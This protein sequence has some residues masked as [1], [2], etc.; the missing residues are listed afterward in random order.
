MWQQT[1]SRL[2]EIYD[3]ME[4]WKGNLKTIE[5]YF[6]TGVVAYFLFIKWLLFLNLFIFALIFLF[7]TLPTILLSDQMNESCTNSSSDCCAFD[8]FNQTINDNNIILDIFQ[9]TGDLERT[10]LF[11]GYYKNI[12]FNISNDLYYYNLPLSYICVILICLLISLIL[13]VRSAAKGFKERLI[14][15]EGQ[16]YHY[17]NIVFSSWDFCIQNKKSAEIKH[18]AI[19]N[20]IVV[21]LENDRWENDH[22]RRTRNERYK[23]I[24]SRIIVNFIVLG[25]LAACGCAIYYIFHISTEQLKNYDQI[26]TT[27]DQIGNLFYEFLPSLT[28]VCLNMLIPFIFR[29]LINFEDY[30]PVFVLRLTLIRTVLLRLASL[31]VL[32]ASLYSKITCDQPQD[33]D[34]CYNTKCNVP[35]CWETYVGQQFYKLLLTDFI[36]H[37]IITFGVNSV[38]AFL[39]KHIENKFIRLIG[40]QSF[41]LPKHVLDVVYSQTLC[42]VG[43]FYAPLLSPIASITFFLMFYIKRFA[44]LYNSKPSTIVYRASRSNSMFMIVL[45]VSY[46]FALL[47]LV[48]SISELVPSRSCGPFRDLESVWAL[49]IN[50]LM[51]TPA[52]IR[53]IGFF[54][55]TAGFVIPLFV[56]LLLLLYYYT[57]VNAANRH[58]VVVLKNQLV[59]EGHDKQFLLDRLSMFI[60]QENQKRLMRAEAMRE[61]DRNISSN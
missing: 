51:E 25:I 11:Y 61:G 21:T 29:V 53:N 10:V 16:F 55:S 40:E 48:Y 35:V 15:G 47:P 41:D 12:T 20:E 5:G 13:I 22:Q 14:E 28:I 57:A 9:G 45:L 23:I 37:L 1:K 31:V 44:C 24:L 27:E 3:K 50:S 39:A 56:L 4:L 26:I 54:M 32:Y 30:R 49:I 17:S 2:L 36:T 19:Y 7:I 58:M 52:W 18:K 8:Y 43:L 34:T 38:R 59:L 42:W 6:G 60:K 46:V 33:T